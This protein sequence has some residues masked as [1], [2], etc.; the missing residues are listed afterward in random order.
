MLFSISILN[1]T[2]FVYENKDIYIYQLHTIDA[3]LCFAL[4]QY[5]TMAGLQYTADLPELSPEEVA[6]TPCVN[7]NE[8][9]DIAPPSYIESQT[10]D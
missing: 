1:Y 7:I 6:L 5:S 3:L 10:G 9:N 4:F 8:S 2:I